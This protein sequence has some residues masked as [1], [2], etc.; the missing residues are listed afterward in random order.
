MAVSKEG[1]EL[2]LISY[3]VCCFMIAQSY[4]HM[5]AVLPVSSLIG[6]SDDCYGL[7]KST[8]DQLSRSEVN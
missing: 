1:C 8:S 3:C 5:R 4:E 7:S 2:V 6:S